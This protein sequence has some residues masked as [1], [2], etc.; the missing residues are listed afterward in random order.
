MVT[1]TI[2]SQLARERER[3]REREFIRE[4]ESLPLTEG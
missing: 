1:L 3:E 4:R 2:F